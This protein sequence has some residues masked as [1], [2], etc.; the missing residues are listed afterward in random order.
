MT[1]PQQQL[2]PELA[3]M[4]HYVDQW[5]TYIEHLEKQ[6][7]TVRDARRDDNLRNNQT[8]NELEHQ[9]ASLR[10]P[11]ERQ[12]VGLNQ[13]LA[14][15]NNELLALKQVMN[16]QMER[17]AL[18]LEINPKARGVTLTSM[19]NQALLVVDQSKQMIRENL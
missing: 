7:A 11:L 9:L 4:H 16:E 12:I 10:E 1:Q 2:W 8:I 5:F 18:V 6:L 3:Q 17:L 15:A 19:V 13:E 14:H